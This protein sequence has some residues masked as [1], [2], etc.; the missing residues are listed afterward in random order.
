LFSQFIAPGKLVVTSGM[1]RRA[2]LVAAAVSLFCLSQPAS[3]HDDEWRG[4]GWRHRGWREHEWREH[5]W[6][7]RGWHG[8]YSP[9][10]SYYTP[11]Y[12]YAPPPAV[13]YEVPPVYVWPPVAYAPPSSSLNFVFGF[14]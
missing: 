1:I 4:G 10:R 3:A 7:D 13:L 11:R 9:Y 6:R 12:Y 8:Y 14:H 5:H 2:A